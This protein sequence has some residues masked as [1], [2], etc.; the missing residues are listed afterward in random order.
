MTIGGKA[1]EFTVEDLVEFG[2]KFNVARPREVIE[3]TV[4]VFS[5][6]AALARRWSV[7]PNEID[8][9]A[10]GLRLFTV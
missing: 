8:A 9:R 3:R 2:K 4:E 6:W 5:G 1:D 10:S 7:A